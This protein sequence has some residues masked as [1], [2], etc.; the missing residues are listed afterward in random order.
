[1]SL[2]RFKAPVATIE[3]QATV[4]AAARAMRDRHV[5]SLVIVRSGRPVGLIT[6]RDIV[7]RVV[8]QGRNAAADVV[9]EFITHDPITVSVHE[10]IETAT[11]RMRRHG[12]RRL[13]LVDEEGMAVGVVTADDLLVLL[14]AEIAAV[15]DGIDNRADAQDSR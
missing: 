14:G 7:L 10:G 12:V 5:G 3:A 6:D 4:E 8:A 1:M 11:I 9:G 15:C 2:A 13:P